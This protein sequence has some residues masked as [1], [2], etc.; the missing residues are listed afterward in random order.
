MRVEHG[1]DRLG[2]LLGH[3][4][5][6]ARVPLVR[7]TPSIP[8]ALDDVV[9]D[10]RQR[11]DPLRLDGEVVRRRRAGEPGGMLGWQRV[12]AAPGVELDDPSGGH[13]SQPLAYV[14]LVEPGRLGEPAAR[15][16]VELCE[17][18]EEPGP[19][20]DRRHHHQ[21]TAVEHVEHAPGERLGPFRVE[22]RRCHCLAPLSRLRREG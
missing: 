14:A 21:G 6:E 5:V 16:A 22:S 20:P 3:D 19:V 13:R 8:E 1:E 2:A 17:R 15:R 11:R 9:L 12:A 18:V 7:H 4:L 10:G